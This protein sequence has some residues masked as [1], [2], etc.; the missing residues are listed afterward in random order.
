MIKSPYRLFRLVILLI[1]KFMLSV[2]SLETEVGSHSHPITN[3]LKGYGH[4]ELF[5]IS[6]LSCSFE[7]EKSRWKCLYG[8]AVD[9]PIRDG[10]N[11]KCR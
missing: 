7:L 6:E 1:V 2:S 9:D 10:V 5:V 4:V 11:G 3:D 8:D